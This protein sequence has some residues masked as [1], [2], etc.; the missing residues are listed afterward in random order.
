[1]QPAFVN[2]AMFPNASRV[3]RVAS[4]QWCA[5]DDDLLQTLSNYASCSITYGCT[6]ASESYPWQEVIDSEGD[7]LYFGYPVDAYPEQEDGTYGDG[8]IHVH[9]LLELLAGFYID[10]S[11]NPCTAAVADGR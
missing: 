10:Y 11:V 2:H 9:D 5:E 4:G 8:I 6:S 7:S 1:M 3:V